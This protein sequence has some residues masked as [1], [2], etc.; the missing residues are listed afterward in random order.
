[1]INGTRIA[2][3]ASLLASGWIADGPGSQA[4]AAPPKPNIIL[5]MAVDPQEKNDRSTE[6]ADRLATM[7]AQLEAW[8]KN[9]T[10]SL[11]GV[12]YTDQ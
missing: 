6:Q 3:I 8:L 12:D 2:L 9:V 4:T 10:D 11:R 1:M 5:C 7:K